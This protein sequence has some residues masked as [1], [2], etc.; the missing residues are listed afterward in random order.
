MKSQSLSIAAL[1]AVLALAGANPAQAQLVKPA[2]G[3]GGGPAF[4]TGNT[5]NFVDNGYN[6]LVFGGI[7]GGILPFGARI[8]GAF[9]HFPQKGVDG[10]DNLWS[11]TANGVFKAA[12]PIVQPY[13]IA[14]VGYYYSDV[15]ATSNAGSF[16]VGASA[17]KFGVNGGVG[18]TLKIPFL[19]RVFAEGRY[20]YVFNGHNSIQYFPLTFGIQL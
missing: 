11:V 20:H 1:G 6:I 8:D 13:I 19:F 12:L 15:S 2:F 4:P 17:S 3:A 5:S 10:H 14:G 16:A 18:A 9:N 7:D